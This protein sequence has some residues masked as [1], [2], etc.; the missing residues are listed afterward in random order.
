[1]NIEELNLDIKVFNRLKRN[2]P[3]VCTVNHLIAE[4]YATNGVDK[5][6]A[7]DMKNI[8][9]ALKEKGIFKYM[10]GDEVSEDDIEPTPLTWEELHHYVG[11][12][13]VCDDST[14]SH[15]WLHLCWIYS[16]SDDGYTNMMYLCRGNGYLSTRKQ[17]VEEDNSTTVEMHGEMLRH[18]GHF[19]ALKKHALRLDSLEDNW[20]HGETFFYSENPEVYGKELTYEELCALPANTLVLIDDTFSEGDEEEDLAGELW[21][22]D[23][24][25]YDEG[26]RF[27]CLDDEECIQTQRITK[28]MMESRWSTYYTRVFLKSSGKET[29]ENSVIET[30]MR[31]PPADASLAVTERYTQA[32]NLN[33]KIWTSIQAVQQNLYDMCTAIKEMRDSKLY[34]EL[35]YSS[36]EAYTEECLGM[37]RHMA[38]K[39]ASIAEIENVESIQHLGATKLSLLAC[40]T[41]DQREEITQ[42]VDLESTTVRELREQIAALKEESELDRKERDNANDAAQ[43]W[44]NTAQSAQADNQRL[45]DQVQSLTDQVKEVEEAK[46]NTR[47]TLK[48]ML[49]KRIEQVHQLEAQIKELENKPQDVAVVDNTEEIDRLNAE[50]GKLRQQLSE[51][52]DTQLALG[53]EPIYQT[54]SKALFKPYL[55]AAAD[56]VNRLAEF[57]GQHS[58]DPNYDFFVGKMQAAFDFAKQK[59]ETM[60]GV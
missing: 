58:S 12:L 40:L 19:F 21:R 59:I 45:E 53:V 43:R 1:M 38:Y 8:E 3:D 10:R 14:Q 23:T 49:D 35:G 11:G 13:V 36:F 16:I 55:T 26:I 47:L 41:D 56:A 50:I 57:I 32:Y 34:K 37:K 27:E 51:K 9:K 7:P 33:V 17:Y 20:P 4:M 52:P 44:K 24:I 60:K 15:R 30:G 6:S 2:L 28:S 39:Y 29:E 46:E 18:A 22:K 48:G 31:I 5:I 25:Q 42:T 54:D